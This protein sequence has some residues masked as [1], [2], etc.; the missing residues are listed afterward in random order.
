M[1]E[2]GL[3]HG[4]KLG[5]FYLAL[6]IGSWIWKTTGKKIRW[7]LADWFAPFHK[8]ESFLMLQPMTSRVSLVPV[9]GLEWGIGCHPWH[10]NPNEWGVKCGKYI[11]LGYAGWP[12]GFASEWYAKCANIA[13]WDRDFVLELG[14]C[15]PTCD[16]MCTEHVG[17]PPYFGDDPRTGDVK[18][19]DTKAD[20][21]SQI[22]RF[23]VAD[24][25]HCGYSSMAIAM[26]FANVPFYLYAN[27]KIN[28]RKNFFSLRP[29][30]IT[31]VPSGFPQSCTKG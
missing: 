26:E 31:W 11:N 29:E 8:I 16:V 28:C 18:Y 14:P 21:L 27:P 12:E 13:G 20:I 30:L 7:L 25:R 15:E 23:A 5:D 4:G 24:E 1:E 10:W 3:T 22:R 6:P 17:R 19:I 9:R 2:I